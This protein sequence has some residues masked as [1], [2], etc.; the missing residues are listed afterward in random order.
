MKITKEQLINII[1]EEFEQLTSEGRYRQATTEPELYDA[2][3][4]AVG[5]YNDEIV[6]AVLRGVLDDRDYY[7][8]SELNE[9]GHTDVPS[10]VMGLALMLKTSASRM[11]PSSRAKEKRSANKWLS[12]PTYK[13]RKRI[14]EHRTKRIN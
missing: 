11:L 2:L 7:G 13:I 10:A 5:D 9:D 12:L 14:N 8:R 3:A 6:K 4:L 1:K